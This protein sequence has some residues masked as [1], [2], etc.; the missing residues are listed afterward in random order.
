MTKLHRI[1]LISGNSVSTFRPK[2]KTDEEI[3]KNDYFDF[4]SYYPNK[5]KGY[6]KLLLN[7]APNCDVL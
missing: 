6:P 3:K 4:N 1:L 2:T 7:E 5:V